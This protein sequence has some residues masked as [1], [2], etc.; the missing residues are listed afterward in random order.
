MRSS[1]LAAIAAV[2]LVT[3][4]SAAVAQTA[5][6]TSP[7]PVQRSGAAVDGESQLRGYTLWIAAAIALGLLIWG[8]IEILDDGDEAPV[9][10]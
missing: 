10:P 3:A 9:S 8:L 4:S 7:A 1:A 5:A 2:S 6:P